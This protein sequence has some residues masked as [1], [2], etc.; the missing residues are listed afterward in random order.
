M[1]AA[2]KRRLG[3]L[4]TVAFTCGSLFTMGLRL[5]SERQS[6]KDIQKAEQAGFPLPDGPAIKPLRS[7]VVRVDSVEFLQDVGDDGDAGEL[8]LHTLAVRRRGRSAKLSYPTEGNP[9][10]IYPHQVIRLDQYSLQI[11]SLEPGESIEVYFLALDEDDSSSIEK[12]IATDFA[13]NVAMESLSLLL[14]EGAQLPYVNLATFFADRF[15]GNLAAWWKVAD[16]IGIYRIRIDSDDYE[17]LDRAY[18]E[19]S[20][21]GNMRIRFAVLSGYTT[22]EVSV[23][24][25]IEVTRLAEVTREVQ[26][27]RIVEVTRIVPGP[28]VCSELTAEVARCTSVTFTSNEVLQIVQPT[29]G[30]YQNPITFRWNGSPWVQYKVYLFHPES[31]IRHESDWI[32]DVHWNFDIPKEEFGNWEWYVV[33]KHGRES[34]KSVFV[35]NPHPKRGG[36]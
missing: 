31:G 7:I 30:E 12:D 10:S 6:A 9:I 20:I 11:E 14:S 19:W 18:D 29:H 5:W 2:H 26:M 23:T 36:R 27:T 33:D 4:V 25:E 24:H 28:Q 15:F 16:F 3:I 35:F 32:Q 34:E 1:E 22:Q 13:I 17:R 8:S 21:D